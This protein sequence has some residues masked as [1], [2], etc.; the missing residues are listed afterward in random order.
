MFNRLTR[1]KLA[2]ALVGLLA[3]ALVAAACGSDSDDNGSGGLALSGLTANQLESLAAQAQGLFPSGFVQGGGINVTGKGQVTAVPDLAILSLGVE[4]TAD[5][6]AEARDIA[7]TAMSAIADVLEEQVVAERDIQ[8]QFF[9]IQPEYSFTERIRVLEGYRVVN[10]LTVKVRDLDNIGPIIDGA[11]EAGGDVTR[12][13]NISFTLENG[14]D[15]EDEART[16]AIQDAVA[17]AQQ[18][19]DET[20]VTLGKLQFITEISA[21]RFAEAVRVDAALFAEGIAVPPTPISIGETQ[22]TV[23]VQASYAID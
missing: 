19:A 18:F 3:L 1:G 20:G 6:V 14:A 17:K 13:N 23:T 12:I 4:A 7:A 10:N 22:V 5:T 21:P 9:S 15:L 11:V 8:T 2:M 16:L